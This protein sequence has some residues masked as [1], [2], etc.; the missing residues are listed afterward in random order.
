MASD[1]IVGSPAASAVD[2]HDLLIRYD[3]KPTPNEIGIRGHIRY[4]I[5]FN[6]VHQG[7]ESHGPNNPRRG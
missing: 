4:A 1:T 6:L 3:V 7:A 5:P 2:L